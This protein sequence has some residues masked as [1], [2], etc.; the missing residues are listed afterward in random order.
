MCVNLGKPILSIEENLVTTEDN[1]VK[2]HT[3]GGIIIIIGF[4]LRPACDRLLLAGGRQVIG[5]PQAF[6][7]GLIRVSSN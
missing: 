7:W 3:T 6:L 1:C 4:F 5:L 2:F